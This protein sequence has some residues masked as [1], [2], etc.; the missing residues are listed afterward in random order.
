MTVV[1]TLLL[2]QKQLLFPGNVF[3]HRK[4]FPPS[5]VQRTF[6]NRKV[7]LSDHWLATSCNACFY[8]RERGQS[9]SFA[10]YMVE[11]FVVSARVFFIILYHFFFLH[12]KVFHNFC[13]YNLLFCWFWFFWEWVPQLYRD[14]NPQSHWQI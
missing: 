14:M 11:I 4:W 2:W 13:V 10:S 7:S 1:Y 12:K 5:P 3:A 6:L 9:T 8:C